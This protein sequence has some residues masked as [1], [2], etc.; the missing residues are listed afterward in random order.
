MTVDD[1]ASILDVTEGHLKNLIRARKVTG[2]WQRGRRPA[3]IVDGQSVR[4]R[5]KRLAGRR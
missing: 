3:W 4:A 1:A 5:R 2:S